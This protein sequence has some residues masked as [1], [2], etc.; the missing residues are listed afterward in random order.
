VVFL[1]KSLTT[2]GRCLVCEV[3]VSSMLGMRRCWP[4]LEIVMKEDD[5]LNS[6]SLSFS[7][8]F[9][10][11]FSSKS[12][13]QRRQKKSPVPSVFTLGTGHIPGDDLLSQ[14]LSSHYHWRCGVSLP[15]SEW[16]RV[17][18]PRSG[19]QRSILFNQDW[20]S[21]DLS[22]IFSDHC[23]LGTDY[24]GLPPTARSLA[25]TRRRSNS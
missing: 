8:F 10:L 2:R 16:D 21:G 19:H 23:S 13:L 5:F 20:V 11:S 3:R 6:S 15:G 1:R 9:S 25:S 17:V 18:P 7:V 14:D 4:P 22:Y 24:C 12:S